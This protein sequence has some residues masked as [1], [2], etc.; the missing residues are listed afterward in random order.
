MNLWLRI[1]SLIK[2][3]LLRWRNSEDPRDV[4]RSNLNEMENYLQ[5]IKKSSLKLGREKGNLKRRIN[6]L[7]QS[8]DE[9]E[10]EAREALKLDREQQAELALKE[11]YEVQKRKKRLLENVNALEERIATLE[12][13]KD[14]LKNRIE[15]FRTKEAELDALRSASEAELRIH[16]IAAGMSDEVF[17]DIHEAVRE[18]ERRLK[19]IQSK[20]QATRELAAQKSASDSERTLSQVDS[21]ERFQSKVQRELQQ[22]EESIQNGEESTE[23]EEED[24]Q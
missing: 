10:D 13:S 5:K 24:S 20:V 19:Q 14:A 16:E 17:S 12:R 6:R 15:I 21:E 2:A 22:L 23:S 7:E 11:K 1:K 3:K 4:L 18:S 8:I 9:Y